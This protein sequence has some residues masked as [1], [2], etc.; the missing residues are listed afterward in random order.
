VPA[1]EPAVAPEPEAEAVEFES[2]ARYAE[3]ST[4]EAPPPGVDDVAE[5]AF[6]AE[7]QSRG[8]TVNATPVAVEIA[9]ETDTKSLPPLNDLVKRIPPDVRETLEELFRAKFIAVKRVPKSAL[10]L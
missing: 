8:E 1:A 6:R 3:A 4:V 7:A 10:K 5:S 9:E 2:A